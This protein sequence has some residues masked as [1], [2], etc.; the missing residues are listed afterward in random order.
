MNTQ[1]DV[2]PG[3]DPTSVASVS[4]SQLL[5]MIAQLA[6]LNNVGFIIAQPGPSLNSPLTQGVGGAPD[7]AGNPRFARY[8]WLN[9]YLSTVA[10]TPYQY[11]TTD[12]KWYSNSSAASSIYDAQVAVGADVQITKLLAG[13]ARWIVRTNSAGTA[14]EFVNP[15]AIF[16]NG[17][18]PLTALDVTGAPGSLSLLQRSATGVISWGVLDVTGSVSNLAVLNLAPAVVNGY[19][20]QTIAGVATWVATS[21]AFADHDITLSKLNQSGAASGDIIIYDGANW[22]KSSAAPFTTSYA[23][24]VVA[25]DKLSGTAVATGAGIFPA[26]GANIQYRVD[27]GL[28]DLS[29]KF[30]FLKAVGFCTSTDAGYAVGDEVPLTDFYNTGT[31]RNAAVVSMTNAGDSINIAFNSSSGALLV[32]NAVGAQA[33]V[34]VSKWGIRISAA[35]NH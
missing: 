12:G 22:A 10:P 6:P 1:F 15:N 29:G 30:Y 31:A 27:H 3:F 28:G 18:V 16:A 8:M 32:I 34:D 11:N 24:D 17:D 5:Q 9:T 13:T 14:M 20:L 21:A 25:G 26:V 33:V 2:V 35:S 4:F 7:V 19:V 23:H